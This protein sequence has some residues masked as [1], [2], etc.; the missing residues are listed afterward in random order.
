MAVDDTAFLNAIE[1]ARLL[2]VT[3]GK[4][5]AWIRTGELRAADVS[6]EPGTGRAR[7]RIAREDLAAFLRSRQGDSADI[8]SGR[9]TDAEGPIHANSQQRGGAG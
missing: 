1:A 9:H 8:A 3:P 7:W 5:F 6:F 4:I 2:R